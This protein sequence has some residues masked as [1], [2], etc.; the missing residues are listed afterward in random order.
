MSRN[1][2]KVTKFVTIP[3]SNY[4]GLYELQEERFEIPDPNSPT[5]LK[6]PCCHEAL[7]PVFDIQQLG[8]WQDHYQTWFVCK[9]CFKAVKFTYDLSRIEPVGKRSKARKAAHGTPARE[10]ME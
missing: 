8:F 1:G 9:P 2:K 4:P 3:N 7:T 6:C 10:E 5:A